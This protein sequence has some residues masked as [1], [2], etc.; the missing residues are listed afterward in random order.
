[1]PHPSPS[2]RKFLPR[3][4]PTG[5][6]LA[7]KPASLGRMTNVTSRILGGLSLCAATCAWGGTY[8]VAPNGRDNAYGGNAPW[9]TIQHAVNTIPA[10]DQVIELAPGT[11]PEEVALDFSKW[12]RGH[13]IIQSKDSANPA[14]ITSSGNQMVMSI[15]GSPGGSVT[16]RNVSITHP[17][18]PCLVRVAEKD[19]RIAFEG[20]SLIGSSGVLEATADA[21]GSLIA[22]QKTKIQAKGNVL[23]V[24]AAASVVLKDCELTWE[25]GPIFQGRA[26]EVVFDGCSLEGS[27]TTL[28]LKIAGAGS[29]VERFEFTHC[30]GTCGRLLWEQGGIEQLLITSNTIH[31]KHTGT[32]TIGAGIE[33]RNGQTAPVVNPAPFK[34]ILIADNVFHFAEDTTHILFFGKGADH[35]EVLRNTLIAP[36][37]RKYGIVLKADHTRFE[38]N[39]IFGGSYAFYLAGGCDNHIRHNTLVS[40][41]TRAF[42]ID[43]N[44]ER[45]VPPKGKYGQPK[46]NVVEDNIFV[47][48]HGIAF[49][50]DLVGDDD[51]ASWNNQV[52]RNVYWSPQPGLLAVLNKVP[53]DREDG[54]EMLQKAWAH[55]G[56]GA[57]NANDAASIVA[58]PLLVNPPED[59]SLAAD[60]PARRQNDVA[61]AYTVEEKAK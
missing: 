27:P 12:N 28:V 7:E 56:P 58:D 2:P 34:K 24:A 10:G 19:L 3:G 36:R 47:A 45:S 43:A 9:S 20:C 41:Q 31:W 15:S 25:D 50:Q 51:S 5:V 35:A 21:S 38:S 26:G 53:L 8:R 46:N 6:V 61:G 11:Y 29:V 42:V 37:S 57:M 1:M 44:Q 22:F 30:R 59:F 18:A 4:N 23:S 39:I 54:V 14:V 32:V 16:F 60:S 40:D 55:Y 17:T 52:N 48:S 49:V 33:V 13:L